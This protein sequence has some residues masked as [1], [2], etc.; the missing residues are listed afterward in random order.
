MISN[1]INILKT[2]KNLPQKTHM[3]PKI[4]FNGGSFRTKREEIIYKYKKYISC[5][6]KNETKINN[7]QFENPII[8]ERGKNQHLYDENHNKFIDYTSQNLRIIAGHCRKD[9]AKIAENQ[10]MKLTYN[11]SD[12]YNCEEPL[13]AE[14]II[15]NIPP[16]EDGEDWVVHFT[17]SSE[18]SNNLAIVMANCFANNDETYIIN[19]SYHQ[20]YRKNNFKISPFIPINPSKGVEHFENVLTFA[21]HGKISSFI[22]DPSQIYNEHYN[23]SDNYIKDCFELVKE[24]GGV[25]IIDETLCGLG[26]TGKNLWSWRHDK[27]PKIVPDII[28]IG[29]NLGNGIVNIGAVVSRRSISDAYLSKFSDP[30]YNHH[31]YNNPLALSIGNK[32]IDIIRS[33]ELNNNSEKNGKLM[34]SE[35][36][37]LCNE[38]PEIFKDIRGRGLLQVLEINNS[39]NK[40]FEENKDFVNNAIHI[41]NKLM[42]FGILTEIT[43][44]NKNLIK[45]YPP[46]C[47]KKKDI[48]QLSRALKKIGENI[49]NLQSIDK[50]NEWKKKINNVYKKG[51]GSF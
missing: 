30:Y 38:L 3:V 11:N 36:K 40:D 12:F 10:M 4:Y 25:T 41:K 49:L 42:P 6:L 32:A 18:E 33:E 2:F 8:L 28:T 17:N 19:K 29:E 43:G 21:S 9:I 7:E 5:H 45:L 39:K 22:I 46:L 47:I 51:Y 34:K 50:N 23:L 48:F 27:F 37:K 13:L 20:M 24:C 15:S 14:K 1:G 16:H 31:K 26:R 44:I 35:M